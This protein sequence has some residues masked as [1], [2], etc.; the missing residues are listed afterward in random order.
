MLAV[1][2]DQA[3]ATAD[4]DGEVEGRGR[5][6]HDRARALSPA[7]G[8]RAA[9]RR[10]RAARRIHRHALG[11]AQSGG[12]L[13]IFC[14]GA[15]RLFAADR[16]SVWIHDRRVRQLVLQASSEPSDVARGVRVSV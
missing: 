8:Q 5:R 14:H 12:G 3:P 13:D 15:N 4:I 11:D 9:A 1:G 6:I 10:A 16:T 2:F 7:P